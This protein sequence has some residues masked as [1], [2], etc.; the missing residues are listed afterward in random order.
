MR[1]SR[2]SEP[3]R[4]GQTAQLPQGVLRTGQAAFG[5]HADQDHL[6]QAKGAVFNLGD[7]LELGRQARH[8]AERLTIFQVQFT[9]CGGRLA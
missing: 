4:L 6:L 2:T 3:G 8:P 5:P 9:G 1:P 7:V